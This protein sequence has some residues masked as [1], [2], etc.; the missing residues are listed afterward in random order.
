M[1]VVASASASNAIRILAKQ[2]SLR[3][4]QNLE[5][6][7]THHVEVI[8][9]HASEIDTVDIDAYRGIEGR[10]IVILPDAADV[11]QAGAVPAVAGLAEGKI[12]SHLAYRGQCL[13]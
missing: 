8:V 1:V 12:G 4:A 5:P 13:E 7:D 9:L 11:D 2:C 6:L 10:Q 3:S